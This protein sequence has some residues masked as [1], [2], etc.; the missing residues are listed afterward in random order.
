M[1]ESCRTSFEDSSEPTGKN[2]FSNFGSLTAPKITASNPFANLSGLSTPSTSNK[3][4]DQTSSIIKQAPVTFDPVSATAKTFTAAP[5]F[6]APPT[7]LP[8]TTVPSNA[9]LSKIAKLNNAFTKWLDR[10][11]VDHPVS[12]WSGGLKVWF[13]S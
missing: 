1:T 6:V 5:S 9:P 7:P 12:I 2:P 13:L 11:S 4:P 10:Q 3:N 8:P